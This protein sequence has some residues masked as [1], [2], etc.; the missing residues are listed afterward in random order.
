MKEERIGGWRGLRGVSRLV[1]VIDRIGRNMKLRCGFMRGDS[2]SR[3]VSERKGGQ[4]KWRIM[5]NM[6][7]RKEEIEGHK[8]FNW[9]KLTKEGS[10]LYRMNDGKEE[11]KAR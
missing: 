10:C 9:W 5:K 1:W 7:R 3:A 11:E 8:V 4:H 2:F 6:N